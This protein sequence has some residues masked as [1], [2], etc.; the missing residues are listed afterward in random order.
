[1]SEMESILQHKTN[2]I[3]T[4]QLQS[5]I[6]RFFLAEFKSRIARSDFGPVID[7]TEG[8]EKKSFL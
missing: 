7:P 4:R 5:V 6:V 1:T 2:I 8:L 3:I